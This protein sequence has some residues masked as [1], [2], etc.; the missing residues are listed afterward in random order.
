MARTTDSH[1]EK[2]WLHDLNH[3][4]TS[5]QIINQLR[6]Y[7]GQFYVPQIYL[8]HLTFKPNTIEGCRDMTSGINARRQFLDNKFEP[9]LV[10]NIDEVKELRYRLIQKT[11]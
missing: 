11:P 2:N 4:Q 9:I 5:C 10:L 1:F 6:L 7:Y 3:S 8:E